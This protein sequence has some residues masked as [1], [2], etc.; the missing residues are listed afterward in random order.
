MPGYSEPGLGMFYS[1]GTKR[2]HTASW[3][4]VVPSK[5]TLWNRQ[6]SQLLPFVQILRFIM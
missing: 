5:V 2:R 4:R 1:V 6:L 3:L